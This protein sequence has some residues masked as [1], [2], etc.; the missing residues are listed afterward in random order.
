MKKYIIIVVVCLMLSVTMILLN[1]NETMKTFIK[2]HISQD[3]FVEIR[4]V[5]YDPNTGQRYCV[6]VLL[7]KKTMVLLSYAGTN[8]AQL[9][10]RLNEE[11]IKSF[12]REHYAEQTQ[13]VSATNEGGIKIR[14]NEIPVDISFENN[15]AKRGTYFEA[16][17]R[18]EEIEQTE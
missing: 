13:G 7:P 8:S 3:D 11:E 16:M 6:D 17:I 10:S 1:N 12:F 4:A 9:Y 5:D 2:S 18:V 15:D 14:V